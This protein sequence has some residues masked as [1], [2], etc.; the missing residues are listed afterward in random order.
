MVDRV[1]DPVVEQNR[2]R[3]SEIEKMISEKTRE[4]A[5]QDLLESGQITNDDMSI[6]N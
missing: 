6:I 2:Q 4:N 3:K 5:I 1:V